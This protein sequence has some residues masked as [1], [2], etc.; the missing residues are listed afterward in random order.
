[1]NTKQNRARPLS[2]EARRNAI[3]EAVIPLLVERGASVTTA[4]MAQ[5]ADIA[6]GTIF[7]VFPDKAALIFEAV[8]KT[9][10]PD[11]VRAAIE[12]IDPDQSL[13]GQ[14]TAA[15]RILLERF[16]R[17]SALAEVLRSM[18]DP[19]N[20][21]R[22]AAHGF[23]TQANTAIS[24]AVAELFERHTDQLLVTPARAAA[25]FRGLIFASA[26]P[27]M[28]PGE[29]LTIDE[30]VSVLSSGILTPESSMS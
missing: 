9:M 6:E 17:V 13:Q 7:R 1:M 4:D 3:L 24:V 29:R 11:S 10:D 14:L 30:V 26:N 12:S 5:A 20:G 27:W 28:V 19:S 22:A 2:P 15:G 16:E 23:V 18:P 25:A 8:K 21:R